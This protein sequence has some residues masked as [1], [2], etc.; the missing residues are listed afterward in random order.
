MGFTQEQTQYE[1]WQAF[2]RAQVRRYPKYLAQNTFTRS[3]SL[4][5]LLYSC[6]MQMSVDIGSINA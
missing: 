5:V 4:F 6:I 1:L 2:P 3:M